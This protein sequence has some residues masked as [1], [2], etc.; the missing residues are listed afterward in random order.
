MRP[1]RTGPSSYSLRRTSESSLAACASC[2]CYVHLYS[3]TSVICTIYIKKK[4]T[5]LQ[6]HCHQHTHTHDFSS[7]CSSEGAV[8]HHINMN[9]SPSS[10]R[11]ALH[12][13]ID[14]HLVLTKDYRSDQTLLCECSNKGNQT[15]SFSTFIKTMS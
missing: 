6:H 12:Y 8:A 14:R 9:R 7:V 10:H 5:V 2:V 11:E 4:S 1:G 3:I 15:Y 13:S